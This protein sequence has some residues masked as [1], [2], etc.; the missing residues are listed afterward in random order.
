M[1]N[2]RYISRLIILQ[3]RCSEIM[4]ISHQILLTFGSEQ[5]PHPLLCVAVFC[6][7]N[8]TLQDRIKHKNQI[9]LVCISESLNSIRFQCGDISAC[10]VCIH[11]TPEISDFRNLIL[12][13]QIFHLIIYL[14][15]CLSFIY[16]SLRVVTNFTSVYYNSKDPTCNTH[17]LIGDN[18]FQQPLMALQ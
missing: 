1:N 17:Y 3:G 6:K 7:P 8:Y 15:N 2:P 18:K 4:P 11:K 9:G 14:I 16:N 5:E 13:L 10:I 12:Y